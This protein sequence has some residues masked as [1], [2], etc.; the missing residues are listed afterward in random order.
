M[1][2]DVNVD[3]PWVIEPELGDRP[4]RRLAT[5]DY[6][7]LNQP[8][9]LLFYAIGGAMAFIGVALLIVAFSKSN[10]GLIA[11]ALLLTIGG[12]ASMIFAPMKAQ[13]HRARVQHLAENGIPIMARILSADNMTGDSTFGRSVRYQVPLP[14]GEMVHRQ[15]NVDERALPKR[16]PA[17]VTALIDMESNDVELY[18]ALPLRA[19]SKNAPVYATPT[20]ATVSTAMGSPAVSAPAT[21]T[22]S[23]GGDAFANLPTATPAPTNN[24]QMGALGVAPVARPQ[25][26]APVQTPTA[27]V[28]QKPE[29][30]PEEQKST[31]AGLPWE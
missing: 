5:T 4:P 1:P 24:G 27:P 13:K 2:T 31:K 20:P 21:A 8:N 26:T 11:V 29:S 18:C 22:A 3:E 30:K 25:E 14:S 23:T 12:A 7:D 15:V 9:A 28:E 10:G 17:N 19:V 16:I 6:P